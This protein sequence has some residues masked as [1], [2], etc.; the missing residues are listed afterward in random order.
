MFGIGTT[1]LLI[2][3]AIAFLLFGNRLPGVLRSFGQ[4]IK[5]FKD[6]INNTLDD[7]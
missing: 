6:G 1:E 4:G 7:K 2:G 5:E 3:L